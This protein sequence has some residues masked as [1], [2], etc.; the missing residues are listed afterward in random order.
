[1]VN[2]N[3]LLITTDVPISSRQKVVFTLGSYSRL[4]FLSPQASPLEVQNFTAIFEPDYVTD[5]QPEMAV[6][7]LVT[8]LVNT[9][10]AYPE[11]TQEEEL[12]LDITYTC[13][14]VATL[15]GDVP[16]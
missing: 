12:S 15:V 6:S 5:D 8:G 10:I 11:I 9:A 3:T 14:V 4:C 16:V 1:M 13:S 2:G 7:Y